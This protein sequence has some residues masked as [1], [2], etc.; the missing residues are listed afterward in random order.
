MDT[1][2][3]PDFGL[4]FDSISYREL[5]ACISWQWKIM[6]Y[7]P[8]FDLQRDRKYIDLLLLSTLNTFRSN[9][10]NFANQLLNE[11]KYTNWT[12]LWLRLLKYHGKRYIYI[13]KTCAAILAN[14][15]KN[16]WK[17]ET[18]LKCFILCHKICHNRGQLE[19]QS[20]IYSLT[21]SKWH[22]DLEYYD[23]HAELPKL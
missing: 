12:I 17:M 14:F 2:K 23:R 7:I 16:K 9:D 19:L 8:I 20:Y 10:N 13:F 21:F 18:F 4:I 22:L 15:V 5:L 6:S 1:P 11:W 3:V